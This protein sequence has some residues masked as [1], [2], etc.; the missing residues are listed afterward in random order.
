MREIW[1]PRVR[2]PASSSHAL[3]FRKA[4]KCTGTGDTMSGDL[5]AQAGGKRG[6]GVT[7]SA[8]RLS[9]RRFLTA[10]AAIGASVA[11]PASQASPAAPASDVAADAGAYMCMS[12]TEPD[13][14]GVQP[15]AFTEGAP[16]REPEV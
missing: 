5:Q 9:R 2:T 1:F 7:E 11:L 14:I 15:A 6:S 8:V 12:G 13:T 16:L 4:N 3:L 10:S